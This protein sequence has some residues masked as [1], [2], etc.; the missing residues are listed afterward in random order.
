MLR[1]VLSAGLLAA[2]AFAVSVS[3]A[4]ASSFLTPS[5]NIGCYVL[6]DSA[7]CDVKARSWR[8]PAK[9]RACDL[10]WGDAIGVGPQSRKASFVCHGDTARD[11]R[12]RR[13][14]YG[15]TIKVGPMRCTSRTDG[16]RC[17]NALGHGFFVSRQSYR[18]F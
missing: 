12:A 7:R 6:K 2:A 9:P 13:L 1:R 18:L 3:A 8:A 14:A 17:A 11:P 10:E 15:R 16:V 4:D 5:G